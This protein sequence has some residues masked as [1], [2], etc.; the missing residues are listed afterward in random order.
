MDVGGPC[1]QFTRTMDIQ[2]AGV[3]AAQ[4]T[5]RTVTRLPIEAADVDQILGWVSRHAEVF[6]L[7]GENV[8]LA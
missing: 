2:S 4:T 7:P 5:Q 3:V 6:V 8:E 1:L